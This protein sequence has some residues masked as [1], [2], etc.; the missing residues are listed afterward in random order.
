M[1]AKTINEFER[2]MTPKAA[3]GIGGITLREHYDTLV[4]PSIDKWQEFITKQ[5]HGKKVTGKFLYFNGRSWEESEKTI[6]VESIINWEL[7]SGDINVEYLN[8]TY[9][10]KL[11]EKYFIG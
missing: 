8:Q 3:M 9:C 7:E 2:G 5:F 6:K 1:R 4:K 10:I 11:D